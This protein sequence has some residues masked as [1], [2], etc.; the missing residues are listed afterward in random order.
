MSKEK[1]RRSPK[2]FK[3]YFEELIESW[4]LLNMTLTILDLLAFATTRVRL[5][6]VIEWL[7]F[8]HFNHFRGGS[9]L[10]AGGGDDGRVSAEESKLLETYRETIQK[11]GDVQYVGAM[12]A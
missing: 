10:E 8:H 5:L 2:D 1:G 9:I 3:D 7:L 11:R 12:S 6:C 4:A